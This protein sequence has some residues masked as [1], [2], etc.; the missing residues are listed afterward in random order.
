MCILIH[1]VFLFSFFSSPSFLLSLDYTRNDGV[2]YVRVAEIEMDRAANA[3]HG[4]AAN[5]SA[6]TA[7][8][9]RYQRATPIEWL[10]PEILSIVLSQLDAK[11][12]MVSVPQVCKRW[13]NMCR[14]LKGVRLDF[15]WWD[16][17]VPV[18]VLAGWRL[19]RPLEGSG[20]GGRAA[21]AGGEQQGN[22]WITGMCELF[23]RATAI[24]ML[25]GH[26]VEDAHVIALAKCRGLIEVDFASCDK[27]TDAALLALADTCCGLMRVYFSYCG[28]LTD[29]ALLALADKCRGL[30]KVRFDECRN[31][32]DAA[33]LAL[34]DKCSGLTRVDFGSCSDLTDAVV[35]QLADKCPGLKIVDFTYCWNLTDAAVLALAHKCR[36]L[37]NANFSGCN[38]LTAAT[39]SRVQ[40]QHPNCNIQYDL[41]DYE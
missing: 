35:L 14:D 9:S 34:A 27:L 40:E 24:T 6:V 15:Q 37:T 32:T 36:E 29:A 31:L 23:P 10:S 16:A 41:H 1:V 30:T 7:E 39:I 4:D 25:P 13:R 2:A 5:Q 17:T 26:G 8:G 33:V 20:G 21:P 3:T 38:N 19:Q 11:T 22:A 18:E 28:N 12:M